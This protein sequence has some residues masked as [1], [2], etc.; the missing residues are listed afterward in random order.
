[1]SYLEKYDYFLFDLDGTITDPGIGITNSVMYALEKFGITVTDRSQ[2]YK[3]IGP[4]LSVS[5]PKYYGFNEEETKSAIQYYRQTYRDKG[6]FECNLYE[7]IEEVL[8]KLKESGKKVILATSKPQEFA[9]QIL[10]HFNIDKYFDVV[11]GSG[12][13]GNRDTKA[14]VIEYALNLA[15]VDNIKR[16][17]MIG[18]REQDIEGARINNLDSVGVLYGYGSRSEHEEAGADYIIES[19][20]E[21]IV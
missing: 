19:I 1:M 8:R 14:E 16:A 21:L 20:D 15:G 3:F 9:I 5:F 2:L 18:D 17:V 6:I 4:P 12:L 11:A 13:D 10:E 7:G